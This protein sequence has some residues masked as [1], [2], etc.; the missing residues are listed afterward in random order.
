MGR[1]WLNLARQTLE[2]A[3][4]AVEAGYPGKRAP[5][6]E[7]PAVALNL[8][9][10]DLGEGRTELTAAVLV[11][12]KMGLALA[13]EKAEEAARA[14]QALGG[15]WHFE[16]HRFDS[17]PDAYCVEVRGKL[18]MEPEAGYRVSINGGRQNWVTD[19]LARQQQDR[20]FTRPHGAS[21]P[22]SV[23]PGMGGWK[24][25]LTQ[26]VPSGSPEPEPE[27]DG[28]DLDVIRAGVKTRYIGCCWDE[29]STQQ[30]ETGTRVIR[31]G[32]ALSREVTAD[33]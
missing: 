15:R 24:I 11:P 19:F 32:L 33:G 30:T 13:Q 7:G 6:L 16:G 1:E 18:A 29:Y 10:L 27:E 14:L 26:M 12:R 17:H 22:G 5:V 20:R 9:G 25:R 31:T 21:A 3:G 2:A 8:T 28:F 4:F 23:T